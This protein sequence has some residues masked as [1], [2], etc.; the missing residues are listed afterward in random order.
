MMRWRVES[1]CGSCLLC[2]TSTL[3]PSTP[4]SLGPFHAL[5]A[6]ALVLMLMSSPQVAEADKFAD[7]DK[8]RREAVETKNSAESLVY[9][10]EKQLKEFAEKVGVGPVGG[11][12]GGMG[13]GVLKALSTRMRSSS[14]NRCADVVL[15][16][17][18]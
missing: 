12:W 3:P 9:Q 18:E 13:Q 7:E 10:T 14:R 8:K 6:W 15:R 4:A 17:P 2:P 16:G 1:A 5:I 11:V